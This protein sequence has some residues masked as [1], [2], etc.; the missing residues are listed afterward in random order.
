MYL[1][2]GT[3]YKPPVWNLWNK[4]KE[5]IKANTIQKVIGTQA[6]RPVRHVAKI[7]YGR[8]EAQDGGGNFYQALEK[9][10]NKRESES[11]RAD[12]ASGGAL[13]MMGGMN[14][15][16]RNAREIFFALSSNADYKC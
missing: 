1:Q 6:V 7:R 10:R 15:Y 11:G 14:Q 8:N 9:A 13:E 4:L 3:N 16:D 2:E 12:T 5:E